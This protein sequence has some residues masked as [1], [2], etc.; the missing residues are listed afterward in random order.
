MSYDSLRIDARRLKDSLLELSEIGGTSMG[1]VHRL[2]L[3]D[4][5]RRARDLLLEWFG[6]ANM[7]VT[8]DEMGNIF[9][10]R[11]GK[12]PELPPVMSGS[13]LD[14]QPKG[15]KLDGSYGVIGALEVARTLNDHDIETDR[16][17][18]VVSWTNEEG[19][20]FAPPLMGSGVYVGEFTLG[21]AYSRV[22]KEG[23][24]FGDELRGI[25]YQGVAPC[26]VKDIHAYLEM[27]IEQGPVLEVEKK[28]IGLVQG[29]FGIV[30]LD[31]T[32]KGE[33]NQ[34][35]PTPMNM[36]RDA[37]VA[38][39]DMIR[40]IRNIPSTV[41]GD[42]VS[43][44]GSIDVV[45]NS[46]NTIPGEVRFTVDFRSAKSESLDKALELLCA[47]IETAAKRENVEVDVKQVWRIPYTPFA[48]NCVE[49]IEDSIKML[50]YN[51]L[52]M[53]SGAGHDAKYLADVCDTG[54]IFVPSIGGRS[55]CEEEATDWKDLEA[56]CN[57]LLHS[58]LKLV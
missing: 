18:E 21:Y 2:A 20:I 13:H 53:T 17:F 45:P 16:S 26:S 32:L 43:T 30:W 23:K 29:I 49:A 50:G 54:M 42:L 6:K 40:A 28:T 57:V 37:L 39:A 52:S 7:E 24:V 56:G 58:V 5:D 31:V 46:R 15:G 3:S 47:E 9:G 22:D 44:V 8:V 48:R 35:G 4:E 41:G 27:H 34:A 1:G 12:N 51:Y 33:S 19:T 11:G 55:H 25:G 10:R 14:T 38:A 36:R